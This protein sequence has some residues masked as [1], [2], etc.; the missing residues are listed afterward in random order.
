VTK[1]LCL[2]LTGALVLPAL[3]QAQDKTTVT[4]L[5]IQVVIS[6]SQGDKKVSSMPYTLS[7]NA[8]PGIR[9][10]K[11]NLRMG[12]KI[13]VPVMT[14][15]SVD[16]KPVKDIPTVAP[17]QYQDVGT[18]IDC[19]AS[20]LDDG[21]FKLDISIDDSSVYPEDK[22]ARGATAGLPS[23]RSFRASDSMILKDG[24][25]A[26]FTAATDKVSGEIVRVDVTLNVV[27]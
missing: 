26:Q 21:R 22:D 11:A 17:V 9:V 3:A 16:G 18:N 12:A 6:R 23:F 2:V 5:K 10:G 15:L 4:P 25:T 19:F 8:E 14:P 7:I 13:P 24:G 1:Q 27:K 20:V